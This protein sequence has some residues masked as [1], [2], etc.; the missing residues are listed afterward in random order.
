[1][2]TPHRSFLDRA[3]G[4]YPLVA[5]YLV[6]LV[7]Y[8]W[9]TTRIPS[10]WIFTDELK[11]S[12]LSR[13][14]AHTGRPEI[15]EHA[16]PVTSLYSY[17]LAPAW[18]LG[19]TSPGYA[20][21]KYLNAAVMT[22]TIFPAYGLARLFLPRLAS[23]VA[24]VATVAIPSLAL[25]GVLMPESLAYFWSAL[26]LYLLA[27][28]LLHPTR[29]GVALAAAAC[30]LA[31]AMRSQLQ[32][33]I[34]AAVIA[35]VVVAVTSERGRA[36]ARAWTW[37][38]WLGAVVLVAGAVIAM[39]VLVAHHSY[40]WYI[41]THYW[42][43]AFTYGLWALGAF[44]IGVGVLPVLLALA[45]AFEARIDTREDRALLGLVIG[46][47]V[48]FGLYTA[49]K[50]SFIST[51][52]AL[53]V[54]ERNVIYLSP[55]AFIAAGRFL[56]R[57]RFRPVPVAA[58]TLA[59]GYLLWT[60]PYHAYEHLYSDAF[61]LS[62][63]Q[64]LNQKWYWTNTDLKRLLFAIL[65]IGAISTVALRWHR[66]FARPIAVAALALGAATI[67]WNL[68]GEIAAA[69]ASVSPGKAQRAVLP[70]PPDWVDRA[71]GR[72]RTM[73]IGKAL[74]NSYWLWSFEFWNQ[75]IQDVW[76]VDA[77]APPPG[78]AVTPNFLRTDGALDPQLPVDW[79]LAQPEI[80]MVGTVQ[81]SAGGVSLY[82]VPHPIRMQSFISGLTA[83]GWMQDYSRFVRFAA[84][85][86]D[87]T[88]TI[89]ISRGAACGDVPDAHFTFRVSS[90]RIDDDGQPVAATR[91]RV[92]RTAVPACTTPPPLKV[93]AR[94][95]FR[96]DATATGLFH[97]GDGRDLSAFVNYAF[98]PD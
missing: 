79:A 34:A 85:P 78:P 91:E 39:D 60:T 40:E 21:A 43:R 15:R 3:L 26:A 73:F 80:R 66:R 55:I 2:T 83:D 70:T 36:I 88:I 45:W 75:S 24:A 94:A 22:A 31:P 49:V 58:A 23:Y 35:A 6:L 54:E 32:V 81:E 51:T 13:S 14:I 76:S 89:S 56:S 20:A 71:T 17:F 47:V 18:W 19:S 57:S 77:S 74:A 64:W 1:M 41:G 93:R 44:T 33:M 12:L 98:T 63:L 16:A 8:A 90:L 95:P 53:R 59:V 11:W 96:L 87:G 61:G 92:V 30:V 46:T 84:K 25:T 62:I 38:E 48:S 42:H 4:A 9:Q 86:V 97:A 50:A 10:P 69:N 29:R 27:R 68:V 82:R 65:I 72:A 37:S 5:T 28:A 67:A 52:F 7:L